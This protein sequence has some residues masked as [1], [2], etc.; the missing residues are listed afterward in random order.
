[1]QKAFV[2]NLADTAQVKDADKKVRFGRE[3]ELED[4]K[5]ILSTPQ[6]QRVLWRYLEHCGIYRDSFT[7]NSS[8]FYNEGRRSIGIKLLEDITTASPDAYIKMLTDHKEK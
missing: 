3:R 4:M 8:T 2:G 1:M 5:F 7:G 6:G